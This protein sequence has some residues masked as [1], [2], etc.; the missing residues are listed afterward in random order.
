MGAA[1]TTFMPK[2]FEE[3]LDTVGF[4]WQRRRQALRS[5]DYSGADIAAVDDL[6]DAHLEGLAAAGEDA[7]SRLVRY[8]RDGNPL[9]AFGG[10]GALLRVG[11]PDALT[12]V[13]DTL[14]RAKEKTLEALRDA[15]AYGPS[16]PLRAQLLSL[17]EAGPPNVSAAAA[18]ILAFHGGFTPSPTQ[19]ERCLGDEEPSVRAAGWRIAA[20]CKTSV[21]TQAVERG[22][23]DDDREA[24]RAAIE[25]AAWNAS[26][27]FYPYCRE[28]GAR[29]SPESV[30][31][32]VL[33]AAVAPPQAY[34]FIEAIGSNPAFGA[35]RFRVVG[36][37][38]HPYFIEFLV[39]QMEHAEP[40]DAKAAGVAF[41]KMTG[42]SLR[43]FDPSLARKAWRQ[44]APSLAHAARICRGFDVTRPLDR[45]AFA[46]LDRESTWE[47]CLRARVTAGWDG[48]PL[49]LERFPQRV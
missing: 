3:H 22:L 14:P 31:T 27:A 16:T 28:I 36:A 1:V 18:E 44:F 8:L 25:T 13:I 34:Q 11:T 42:S 21:A 35:A 17:F 29:P 43:A 15:L 48:T 39:R 37:F 30:D 38:G 49:T 10:A 41:Q 4:V 47:F 12:A 19:L 20:Y 2:V 26:P 23:A 5:A 7:L 46:Q 45:I 24:R 40:A 9:R 6:I 33:L 32:L